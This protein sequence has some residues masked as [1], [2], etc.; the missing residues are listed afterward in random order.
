MKL[1]KNFDSEEFASRDGAETPCEVMVNLKVLAMNLQHL[2]DL[3]GK[4]IHIN[5][6]YRSPEHNREVGGVSN[7]QHLYGKAADIT[8]K[9]MDPKTVRENILELIRRGEMKNGGIGIYDSFVH[10]DIRDGAAR[11]DERN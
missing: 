9:G 2:R 7:S 6:G 5:S 3:I 1:T 10:Y 11:W 8:V 4:P